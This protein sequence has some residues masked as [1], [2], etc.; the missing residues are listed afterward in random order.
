MKPTQ[1][2]NPD[3]PEEKNLA[4]LFFSLL[5]VIF[6]LCCVG[7]YLRA[8]ELKEKQPPLIRS[9]KTSEAPSD[10]L[11]LENLYAE[12]MRCEIQFS[13]IVLRQAIH[14]T[15]WL[16]S[17]NCQKRNNLF[18]MKGGL[19]TESNPNGYEIYRTWQESVFA[20]RL[21]QI[22]NYGDSQQNY[23]EFLKEIGYAEDGDKY[24]RSLKSY[25][26]IIIKTNE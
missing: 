4:G 16:R 9:C 26:I 25:N 17:H 12:I 23:Y 14:E 7:M 1:Y 18:G 8:Q 2:P 5:A 19:K 13:E 21:W 11:T 22:R 10:S 24:V 6:I 20:Y 3:L 15:G